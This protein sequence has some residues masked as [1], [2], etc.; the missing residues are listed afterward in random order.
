MKKLNICHSNDLIKITIPTKIFEEYLKFILEQ[1]QK[2]SIV[3]GFHKGTAPLTY[4]KGIFKDGIKNNL[5][6]I[7]FKTYAR[8]A[9]IN[10]YNKIGAALLFNINTM[11]DIDLNK[12]KMIF[13]H[14]ITQLKLYEKIK[15]QSS[16]KLKLVKRK[17]YKDLDKQAVQMVNYES[18]QKLIHKSTK[19]EYGDWIKVSID[20]LNSEEKIISKKTKMSLWIEIRKEEIFHNIY[21]FFK[22]KKKNDVFISDSQLI[23]NFISS[24]NFAKYNFKITVLEHV[25]CRYFDFSLFAKYF[26]CKNKTEIYEKLIEAFSFK[27]DVSMYKLIGQSIFKKLFQ[28]Y[29][30]IIT[31]KNIREYIVE[32]EETIKGNPDYLLYQSDKYF[33][34]NVNKFAT[35]Q[36]SEIAVIDYLTAKENIKVNPKEIILYLNMLQRNRLKEFL[37]FDRHYIK[38]L[39]NCIIPC[40]IIEKMSLRE[41]TLK[42]ITHKMIK[43][44]K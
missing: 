9:I 17:L 38:S 35:E 15:N 20:V 13:L 6:K 25:S 4:I 26:N 27:N 34:E 33:N 43:N 19:I 2:N 23:Q 36:L 18:T 5:S 8:K 22:D 14:K 37:Y 3:T 42:H 16:K 12:K 39:K 32:L 10:K 28:I 41:K 21:I 24:N 7:F 31:E 30:P 40:E 44:A 11:I 29:K 1:K